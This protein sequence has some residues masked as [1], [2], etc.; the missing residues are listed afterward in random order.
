MPTYEY[1][2]EEGHRFERFLKLRDYKTPQVCD[3]GRD[4][5]KII[6]IPMLNCDIKPWESYI[7]PSTGRNITSYKERRQDMADSG[8]ID[9]EPLSSHTTKHM[10]TE[11]RKLEKA[12]DET[13]EK[14]ISEMPVRKREKLDQEL[15]SGAVCSYE[16]I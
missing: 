8:C 5:R 1:L 6:S 13:V 15:K 2:C 10:E 11:D 12:M 16:R 7:S 4:S 3:C 9:Y 14:T